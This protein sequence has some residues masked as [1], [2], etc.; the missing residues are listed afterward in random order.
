VK[1]LRL[2][3]L[4]MLAIAPVSAQRWTHAQLVKILSDNKGAVD[5]LKRVDSAYGK[6]VDAGLVKNLGRDAVAAVEQGTPIIRFDSA[7]PVSQELVVRELCRLQLFAEGWPSI[8]VHDRSGGS[9]QR[10]AQFFLDNIWDEL[11]NRQIYPRMRA[12]GFDPYAQARTRIKD[13]LSRPS[14]AVPVNVE[15][16]TVT[17]MHVALM[18]DAALKAKMVAWVRDRQQYAWGKAEDLDWALTVGGDIADAIEHIKVPGPS[19]L[20]DASVDVLLR[21]S[22]LLNHGKPV[23]VIES[24]KPDYFKNGRKLRLGVIPSA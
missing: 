14:S 24:W 23:F 19:A 15:G 18:D 13:F 20:P 3:V 11:Q 8:Q 2:A 16:F 10:R 7:R 17:Y 5:L 1:T 21:A 6:P 12:I 9:L 22:A 4:L